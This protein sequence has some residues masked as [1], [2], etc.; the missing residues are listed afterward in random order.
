MGFCSNV[1]WQVVVPVLPLHLSNIGYTTAQI[2]VLISLISLAMGIVEL[3]AGL[4]AAAI[5]RRWALI[6]GFSA[7][8][9]GL[10]LAG[11]ARTLGMVASALAAVGAAKG[12]VVP[13]LHAT[14]AESST[15]E[16]RGRT[17]GI[18][19]F[20]AS[21]AALTGPAIGG[22]VATKYGGRAPFYLGA[23]FCAAALPIAAAVGAA[24]RPSPRASFT[25][26]RELVRNA[27]VLRLCT[28]TLLCFGI[29]G[30]WT[31]FLP[32]YISRQGISVAVIGWVF[33]IQ[34][35]LYALMQIPTGRLVHR[36]SEARLAVIGVAGI[37]G[38]V[39]LVPLLHSSS[40]FFGAAA[41]YG[42]AFGLIPVT[43]ATLITRLVAPD[44]YTTAM[45]VY[46]S[47]IDLGLFVGPLLGGAAAAALGPSASFF[48]VL[49]LGLAAVIV[50][51]RTERVDR[52][53]IQ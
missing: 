28:A 35:F 47:A 33:T 7:N 24:G 38:V 40:A 11:N 48:V 19:W 52:G 43:F 50:T 53:S 29:M 51:L 8:A 34:G 10:V 31:A 46:N 25:S 49:P 2:G 36:I 37:G 27:G 32:L 41:V 20:L 12:T 18:F 30:I 45:G 6:A 15:A 9:V 16:T 17:F 44:K 26:I 14:V 13:P 4:I 5:G 22:L 23:A 1:S 42:C 39:L 3:Q 21:T